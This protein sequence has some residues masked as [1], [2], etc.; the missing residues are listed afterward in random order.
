[1]ELDRAYFLCLASFAQQ[2]CEIHQRCVVIIELNKIFDR[3][4]RYSYTPVVILSFGKSSFSRVT[5]MTL[6]KR[7]W[8]RSREWFFPPEKRPSLL[9]KTVIYLFVCAWTGGAL[10]TSRQERRQL[11][12]WGCS[13][14]GNLEALNKWLS[15]VARDRGS[16]KNYANR[17]FFPTLEWIAPQALYNWDRES[18]R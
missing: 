2:V 5:R 18:S 7:V 11:R 12:G 14:F 16:T 10:G 9:V 3:C 15:T 1:M 8:W 6:G 4:S 17:K 13:S